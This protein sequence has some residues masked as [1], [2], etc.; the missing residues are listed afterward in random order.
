MVRRDLP[1][2]LTHSIVKPKTIPM[3]H[4]R[5]TLATP[6]MA[7]LLEHFLLAMATSPESAPH[8]LT[9]QSPRILC[10]W[11]WVGGRRSQQHLFLSR[12]GQLLQA[13]L[14]GSC[15]GWSSSSLL[16]TLLFFPLPLRIL[17]GQ[18]EN[19]VTLS[20]NFEHMKRQ[21]RMLAG[22]PTPR[23]SAL[24]GSWETRDLETYNKHLPFSG[25]GS[26]FVKGGRWIIPSI[27]LPCP[28]KSR[29]SGK[30]W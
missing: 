2:W 29:K 24:P 13:A 16:P 28:R 15:G 4:T 23:L 8:L 11:A 21:Q 10:R 18:A 25:L 30:G 1:G 20:M 6:A 22:A 3:T 27:F 14:L 19:P 5:T 26:P 17:T 7:H 12:A 9:A